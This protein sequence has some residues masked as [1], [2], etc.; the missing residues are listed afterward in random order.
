MKLFLGNVEYVLIFKV[1]NLPSF[2]CVVS[3]LAGSYIL[4]RT[5]CQTKPVTLSDNMFSSGF[6]LLQSSLLNRILVLWPYDARQHWILEQKWLAGGPQTFSLV[7]AGKLIESLLLLS[8]HARLWPEFGKPV[9]NLLRL[10]RFFE[11]LCRRSAWPAVCKRAASANV[12]LL[13][14]TVVLTFGYSHS[15]QHLAC[16]C[17]KLSYQVMMTM[18]FSANMSNIQVVPDEEEL[19]GD[20]ERPRYSRVENLW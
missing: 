7:V 9:R 11:S 10:E 2:F 19:I 14:T 8:A 17:L 15:Y 13:W 18:L 20:D 3:K 4:V 5:P 16:F 1:W 12:K 6:N